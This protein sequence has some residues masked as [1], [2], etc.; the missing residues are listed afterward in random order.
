MAPN[1]SVTV[2]VVPRE[3]FSCAPGTLATL[4]TN[5]TAPYELV[6]VDGG[7]PR[8]VRR[9]LQ[10]Q[11]EQHGFR[12]VR[13][14]RYL[15]PNEARNIALANV[16]TDY[17]VFVDNDVI[18]SP[19]WLEKLLECASEAGADVVSPLTLEGDPE[20][21]LIHMAG[22]EAHIN[23]EVEAGGESVRRVEDK[24]RFPKR[25]LPDV[26]S[27]LRREETGLI[28]FHC[29]MVRTGLFEQIGP[30]DE[31]ML[32]TREHVDFVLKVAEVGGTIWLEPD[33]VVTYKQGPPFKLYDIPYFMLRWSDEWE[34]ASLT[35]FQRKWDLVQD[36][37]FERRLG[38]L[39]WRRNKSLLRPLARR[40]SLGREHQKVQHLVRDADRFVNRRLTRWD[41]RRR[42]AAVAA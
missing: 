8:S 34:R 29:V 17:V 26:R 22:G 23:V 25:K 39:G 20:D 1:P 6:Y 14:N 13:H 19:G 11:A 15:A 41:S 42:T 40:I 5:T 3:R 12:L 27:H 4:L 37:Y 21:G 31:G 36:E 24:M 32:S 18:V 10:Q 30:L 38:R 16:D 9:H 28:E 33:S 2:A 7:S 35:H